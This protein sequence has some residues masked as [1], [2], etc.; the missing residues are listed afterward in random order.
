MNGTGSIQSR[1]KSIKQTVQII[2]AQKLI[3]ASKVGKA[4]KML[5]D[6]QPYHTKILSTISGILKITDCESHASPYISAKAEQGERRGVL[7]ISAD[8]GLAGGYNTNLTKFAE[9]EFGRQAPA[10]LMVQGKIGRTAFER[11][12][13]AVAE[14]YD[15]EMFGVPTRAYARRIAKYVFDLLDSGAVDTFDVVY[16][17]YHSA[18]K[19]NPVC[20]RLL[21]VSPC[22]LGNGIDLPYD[23]A[24]EPS[25]QALI[26]TLIPKYLSG[27]IYGALVHAYASELASRVTAMDSA[28][29][30]GNDMLSKL[31]LQYNRARQAAI[32]QEITE[33]VAGAEAINN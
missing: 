3:A 15:L 18:V 22:G 16:T 10:V 4:R 9:H 14:G 32:T 20:E 25:P 30:N 19:Q 27:Y 7:V 26:A 33:I 13:Q 8:V 21:P 6:A 28:M 2:N 29:R 24:F 23:I 17:Y 11:R 31:T 1:M 12:N 5:D